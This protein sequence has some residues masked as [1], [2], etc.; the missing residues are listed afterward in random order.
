MSVDADTDAREVVR[1]AFAAF[2]DQTQQPAEGKLSKRAEK[3]VRRTLSLINVTSSSHFS[4]YC[5]KAKLESVKAKRAKQK[6]MK[7]KYRA[8]KEANGKADGEEEAARVPSDAPSDADSAASPSTK[9]P[10]KKRRVVRATNSDSDSDSEAE[11]EETPEPSPKRQK[12]STPS[13]SAGGAPHKS[14]SISKG[15]SAPKERSSGEKPMPK[16]TLTKA[17][18]VAPKGKVPAKVKSATVTQSKSAKKAHTKTSTLHG[19]TSPHN[20]KRPRAS[21]T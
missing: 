9:P 7:A 8:K 10:L 6:V 13:K 18:D 11:V 12:R 14:K 15:Q 20:R 4:S 2:Q 21:Q 19:S 16:A 1:T 3:K 17:V 5:Q